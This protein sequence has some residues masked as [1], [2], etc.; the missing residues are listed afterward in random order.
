[1]RDGSLGHVDAAAATTVLYVWVVSCPPVMI[2]NYSFLYALPHSHYNDDCTVDSR[3]S[4]HREPSIYCLPTPNA[5]LHLPSQLFHVQYH[6]LRKI[7]VSIDWIRVNEVEW[8]LDCFLASA[9]VLFLK[10]RIQK[11]LSKRVNKYYNKL[12]Y[13]F[14]YL[15]LL[16]LFLL[17]TSV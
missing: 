17:S 5:L 1:M 2:Y 10:S 13:L 7:C 11:D 9:Y 4:L 8:L 14:V 12:L 16:V 6:H 15:K 3:T